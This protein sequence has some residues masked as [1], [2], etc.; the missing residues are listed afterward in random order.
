MLIFS[1]YIKNKIKKTSSL[2]I[3]LIIIIK[4]RLRFVT[5]KFVIPLQIVLSVMKV[6]T[7]I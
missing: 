6:N 1:I 2:I 4:L 5:V 3:S 7:I